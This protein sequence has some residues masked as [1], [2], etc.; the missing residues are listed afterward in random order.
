MGNYTWNGIKDWEEGELVLDSDMNAYVS[1]N[2]GFIFEEFP[3]NWLGANN[4]ILPSSDAATSTQYQPLG[5]APN[6]KELVY[7]GSADQSAQWNLRSWFAATDMT[8]LKIRAYTTDVTAATDDVDIIVS[9][10]A[11]SDGDGSVD[12]KSFV[13]W[14][15]VTIPS[16]DL[17]DTAHTFKT[18]SIPASGATDWDGITTGDLCIAQIQRAG[19]A[20]NLALNLHIERMWFY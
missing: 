9:I 14:P 11:I 19:S 3:S 18:Y 12:S 7:S 20:D 10:A 4:S 13:A 8:G 5:N 16:S 15:T 17:E 6:F 1:N 2:I